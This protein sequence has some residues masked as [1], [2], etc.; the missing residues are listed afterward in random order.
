MAEE[1]SLSPGRE[2]CMSSDSAR[3]PQKDSAAL[4]SP[5]KTSPSETPSAKKT[6]QY[7]LGR[8]WSPSEKDKPVLDAALLYGKRDR[9]TTEHRIQDTLQKLVV[10]GVFKGGGRCQPEHGTSGQQTESIHDIRPATQESGAAAR[11]GRWQKQQ[12]KI[13]WADLVATRDYLLL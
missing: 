1:E 7:G 11:H 10:D 12:P 2:S 6:V 4:A 3:T 8:F 5:D 9:R 13:C